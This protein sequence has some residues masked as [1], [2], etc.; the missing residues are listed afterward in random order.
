MA[1][2]KQRPMPPKKRGP[3]TQEVEEDHDLPTGELRKTV[4]IIPNVPVMKNRAP[5]MKFNNQKPL[6]A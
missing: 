6:G 5:A 4:A 1:I 2:S 3:S